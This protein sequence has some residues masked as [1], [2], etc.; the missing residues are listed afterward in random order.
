MVLDWLDI[1]AFK[2]GLQ[3]GI[4][5]RLLSF[6]FSWILNIFWGAVSDEER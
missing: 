6:A 4:F 2:V 3:L 1:E 5:L